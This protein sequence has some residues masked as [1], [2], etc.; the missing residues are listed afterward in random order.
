MG[1]VSPEKKEEKQEG[2]Q[3]LITTKGR[4]AGLS[5]LPFPR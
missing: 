3:V 5:D 4:S 2:G 1:I